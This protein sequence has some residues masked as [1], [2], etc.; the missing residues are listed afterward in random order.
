MNIL[1]PSDM[2]EAA[3]T[4]PRRL[5]EVVQS[6]LFDFYRDVGPGFNNS[7]FYVQDTLLKEFRRA[8]LERVLTDF[9]AAGHDI[10]LTDD[11]V[12]MKYEYR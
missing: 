5:Y 9:R 6:Y 7:S 3:Q 12:E 11:L 4:P 2:I 10:T 1:S 8:H